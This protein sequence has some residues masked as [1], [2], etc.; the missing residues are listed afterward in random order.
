MPSQKLNGQSLSK[1]QRAQRETNLDDSSEGEIRIMPLSLTSFFRRNSTKAQLPTRQRAAPTAPQ[2]VHRSNTYHVAEP[3]SSSSPSSRFRANSTRIPPQNNSSSAAAAN[4]PPQE[5]RPQTSGSLKRH[6]A[7]TRPVQGRGT[8]GIFVLPYARSP[9]RFSQAERARNPGVYLP[10]LSDQSERRGGRNAGG[11]VAVRLYHCES[12]Y[13]SRELLASPALDLVTSAASAFLGECELRGWA[14]LGKRRNPG[15]VGLGAARTHGGF[16]VHYP[17]DAGL[18]SFEEE[19]DCDWEQV[20]QVHRR[21]TPHGVPLLVG[22][23]PG[24][25]AVKYVVVCVST[26]GYT[27]R[28]ADLHFDTDDSPPR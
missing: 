21:Y 26:T 13:L 10:A 9:I 16:H 8:R 1:A 12:L 18:V 24:Q 11:P 28:G 7:V 25:A 22:V 3:S 14:A 5:H 27:I 2:P 17:D 20:M 19:A 6:G 15:Y 4:T 23:G